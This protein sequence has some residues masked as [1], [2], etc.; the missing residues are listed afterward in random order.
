MWQIM[1]SETFGDLAVSSQLWQLIWFN[2]MI[3]AV[4]DSS[5][6]L[7]EYTRE[8]WELKLSIFEERKKEEKKKILKGTHTLFLI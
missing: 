8:R 1:R 3:P 6:C 5:L 7:R 4:F 2:K